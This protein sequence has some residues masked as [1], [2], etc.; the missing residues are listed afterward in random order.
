[1][2]RVLAPFGPAFWRDQRGE[3]VTGLVAATAY[4]LAALGAFA[5]FSS[6]VDRNRINQCVGIVT[7]ATEK[8]KQKYPWNAVVPAD[9]IEVVRI[10]GCRQYVEELSKSSSVGNNSATKNLGN[11]VEQGLSKLGKCEI[12]ALFPAAP[13]AGL[14]AGISVGASIPLND[15]AVVVASTTVHGKSIS[16]PLGG[17]GGSYGGVLGVP[18]DVSA[19]AAGEVSAVTVTAT[20]IVA[21]G[22][23]GVCIP[24]STPQGGQCILSC[25]TPAKNIVWAN[26]S[27]PEIKLFLAQPSTIDSAKPTPVILAWNVA[28]ATSVTIDQGVGQVDPKAGSTFELPPDQDTT[29]TLT[30]VGARPQDTRTAQQTVKVTNT[31]PLS[32]SITSPGGNAQLTDSTVAVTGTVSPAPSAGVSM[33]ARISVN[34]VPKASVP[35][36]ASGNFSGAAGLDRLTPAAAVAVNNPSLGVN[37]CGEKS[38]SVT[39]TNRA[40]PSSVQNTIEV[41]VTDGS[42]QASAAVT[43]FHAVLLNSFV[44]N[45][46]DCRPLDK[47]QARSSA[48]GPGQ[49]AA[50]GTVDCGCT[51][52]DGCHGACTVR[53][54]VG[55]SVGP[56]ESTATWTFN[57]GSCPSP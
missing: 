9:D 53:A 28:D 35:V 27:V 26:P 8:L 7:D 32:V 1:M 10:Q 41:T 21:G 19:N 51:A 46:L 49:T 34:G 57:V 22:S 48:I 37:T 5:G 13:S 33:T 15:G 20:S 6:G 30:A 36:D 31:Q 12:D 3:V 43:V 2:R 40:S 52:K 11:L 18:S 44:V 55:T 54:R 56:A 17:S 25:T 24:P 45:W 50:V 16:A 23:N 14:G 39:V 4:L 47:N 42:R 38:T 29:Y